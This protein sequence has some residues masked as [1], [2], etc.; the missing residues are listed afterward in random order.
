M[1]K[2]PVPQR[3]KELRRAMKRVGIDA[4]YVPSTDA[5]QN[6]YVPECWQRR[7]WL[8]GFTG[9]AGDL[10][11]T[12]KMAGLWTDGRYFLQAEEELK[13]SGVRLF[14]MGDKGVPTKAQFLSKTLKKGEV[15]GVDPLVVSTRESRELERALERTG[16][17]FKSVEDNLVDT[18]WQD[19]PQVSSEQIMALPLRFAGESLASKLKRLR[20]EMKKEGTDAQ[21]LTTLD[22]IAWLYNIRGRDVEYNPVAIA[23]AVVTLNR[24]SLFIDEKKVPSQ[25]R[26]SLAKQV[27]IGPYSEIKTALRDLGRDRATVWIDP[28]EANRWVVDCLEGAEIVEQASAVGSMKAK[29]NETELA[30]ARTAHLRDGVAMVRFLHWLEEA[31][32][33]GGVTEISAADPVGSLFVGRGSIFK[34]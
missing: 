20:R 21:V 9:S 7:P 22:S 23:Y 32:P 6:E 17:K 26:R 13:G 10:L 33:R 15:L 16:A 31:V 19:R 3:L 24:A 8:S 2:N 28:K 14:R 1:P 5:H 4:Y 30:G 25:V 29:K 27:Q 11:V 34:V 12:H 18:L